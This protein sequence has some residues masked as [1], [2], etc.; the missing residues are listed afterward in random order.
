MSENLE[1]K[2]WTEDLDSL[3]KLAPFKNKTVRKEKTD[4]VTREEF[5]L[6]QK[7]VANIERQ[8]ENMRVSDNSKAIYK[9][10]RKINQ[11]TGDANGNS[12]GPKTNSK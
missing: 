8:L 9:L 12:S 10:R 1:K 11:L 4:S 2:N 3:V 5:K 7:Q 6:L